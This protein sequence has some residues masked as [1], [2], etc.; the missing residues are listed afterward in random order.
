MRR[1]LRPSAIFSERARV[2]MRRGEI[3]GSII[4]AGIILFVMLTKRFP[5]ESQIFGAVFITLLLFN[6]FLVS[7]VPMRR[8]ES[9]LPGAKRGRVKG[10]DR[11]TVR[12]KSLG[13][14]L[15]SAAASIRQ[16]FRNAFSDG[17]ILRWNIIWEGVVGIGSR[18]L[19]LFLLVFP[20]Y[21]I[22]CEAY[23][24]SRRF[25]EGRKASS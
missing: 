5:I 4:C 19:F 7:L 9:A 22:M 13:E 24:R 6:A 15:A 23:D 3:A 8:K 17:F 20:A 11:R 2:I 21:R 1:F 18:G 25:A 10:I 16:F 12:K 14:R